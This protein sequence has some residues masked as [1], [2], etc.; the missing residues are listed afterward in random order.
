MAKVLEF[1]RAFHRAIQNRKASPVDPGGV[2]L[3]LDG[4]TAVATLEA[5]LAEASC[6]GGAEIVQ[7][8]V[9]VWWH[10]Q[11]AAK[12]GDEALSLVPT[13]GPRGAFAAARG[14]ALGGTRATLFLGAQDVRAVS[15]Q[16][17]GAVGEHLPL[18]VYVLGEPDGGSMSGTV[19]FHARNVQEAVDL[20]LA[21][22]LV[23]EQALVPVFVVMD[24]HGVA[25]SVQNVNLPTPGEVRALLGTASDMVEACTSAQEQLF[26]SKR[27]RVPARFDLERGMMSGALGADF[28]RL[29][30]ISE[31]AFMGEET[32]QVVGTSLER[33][34]K[35]T[36]RNLDP[37]STFLVEG[38]K[39]I[40]MAAGAVV[41]TLERIAKLDGEA[42]NG[43]A[44]GI[45]VVGLRQVSP[46]PAGWLASLEGRDQVIVLEGRDV[47]HDRGRLTQE[48]RADMSHAIENS[49]HRTGTVS[50]AWSAQDLPRIKTAFFRD[51]DVDARDLQDLVGDGR[52]V[53]RLSVEAGAMDS[54]FPKRQALMD[55]LGRD[56]PAAQDLG[57]MPSPRARVEFGEALTIGVQG[58]ELAA[59][60]AGLLG[61]VHGGRLRSRMGSG[62]VQ[63]LTLGDGELRHQDGAL[64]VDVLLADNLASLTRSELEARIQQGTRVLLMGMGPDGV[65]FDASLVNWL[66][67][68]GAVLC[69]GPTSDDEDEALELAIGALV[70]CA[71]AQ[72]AELPLRKVRAVREQQLAGLHGSQ[73]EARLHALERG[74]G[75]L[76]TVEATV[77]EAPDTRA[78]G[79][80]GKVA[81]Q[82]AGSGQGLES[83]AR[84]W[85]ETGIVEG[86]GSEPLT[87][88]PRLALRS[89]PPLSA[90]FR[91]LSDQRT[92]LPVFDPAACDGCGDCWTSC[93]DGALVPIALDWTAILD[94]GFAMAKGQG[95]SVDALRPVIGKVASAAKKVMGKGEACH[96]AGPIL[97]TA[98]D[99]LIDRLASNEERRKSLTDAFD[100]VLSQI[101]GFQVARTE[102]CFDRGDEV[103]SLAIN[104]ASC[105][106][107]G[108]CVQACDGE[109]LA[110]E[111]QT[112]ERLQFA[113]EAYH[114]WENL[115]DTSGATVARLMEDPDVGQAAAILMSRHCL[116]AMSGGT[117]AEP[118]CGEQLALR[119]ALAA[120]EYHLQPALVARLKQVN[121]TIEKVSR[122]VRELLVEALPSNDSAA[123][124]AALNANRERH[125][126]LAAFLSS[127]NAAGEGKTVDRGRIERLHRLQH[128]LEA[129]RD[130]LAEGA[131]GSGRARSSLAIAGGTI[132]E[133]AA[134]FPYNP[135]P[136]PVAVDESGEA[137]SLARGLIEGQMRAVVEDF[138]VLRLAEIEL[139]RPGQAAIEETRLRS[140]TFGDLTDLERGLCPPLLLVGNDRILGGRCLAAVT[141]LLASRL[142]VKILSL[143]E[144]DLGL[145]RSGAPAAGVSGQ[146]AKL[147]LLDRKS[148]VAQSSVGDADH[149]MA[150]LLGALDY[151]G[152]ALIQV[153][154]PSPSRHGFDPSQTVERARGA[155]HSRTLQLFRFDPGC[156]GV[157]GTCLDLQGNPDL[158]EAWSEGETPAHWALGE[159]RFAAFL[160]PLEDP[161]PTPTPLGDWLALDVPMRA[162]RTP[163]VETRRGGRVAVGRDL[164]MASERQGTLWQTLQEM[165]GLVTPFTQHV[166]EAA[167]AQVAE[168]HRA[169]IQALEAKHAGEMAAVRDATQAELTTRL[170]DRLVELSSRRAAAATNGGDE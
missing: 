155:I 53:V 99:G 142:P 152:P 123:L 85:G 72:G 2:E 3:I 93:P 1:L 169:E 104:P 146:L 117:D 133:W 100:G 150:S 5:S 162:D 131:S 125:V 76:N 112:P 145:E 105:K 19:Q 29:G 41:E 67:A 30:A 106:A 143:D 37:L 55:R 39:T 170:R 116:L 89:M 121:S 54:H 9:R 58:P 168:S 6:S 141:E 16:I 77:S 151:V 11:L 111:L 128:R 120:S 48:L 154:T 32:A 46:L 59:T 108:A 96:L 8:A 103:F 157:F 86:H 40:Y 137:A 23:A 149:L 127:A 161:D 135:F 129:L 56:Y 81:D 156:E 14:L 52:G 98:F 43:Q 79:A 97:R 115:P 36:G 34:A 64:P 109:G 26:G 13:P 159:K 69:V 148:Y 94:A 119:H 164:A 70:A 78:D 45:G 102:A 132:A 38:A 71:E 63:T 60:L 134:A 80:P 66:K 51:G 82:V 160:K 114:L 75:G 12:E 21:A 18:V 25:T 95:G 113:R 27:R 126:D 57:L 138:R 91:D 74:H 68:R 10:E 136:M 22:R 42:G 84:F 167:E 88:E 50:P 31:R 92:S 110:A 49:R 147:A 139:T 20:G 7:A 44:S 118:G 107:C 124:D 83:L 62:P 35:A 61:A 144:L 33:V 166:Q 158:H 101:E 122:E 73:L 130:R 87:P 140:L 28:E 17:S 4:R 24:R 47:G 15:D 163:F 90:A 165:A 65:A 153:H